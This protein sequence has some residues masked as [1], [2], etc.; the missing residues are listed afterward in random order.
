VFTACPVHVCLGN[1]VWCVP[2]APCSEEFDESVVPALP[3]A[4]QPQTRGSAYKVLATLCNG[5]PENLM[6]L[7]QRLSTLVAQTTKVQRAYVG[8]WCGGCGVRAV[9][10]GRWCGGCGVG[11]VVWGLW[12]G[13][14]GMGAVVWGRWCGGCGVVLRCMGACPV[15]C[16]STP[17]AKCSNTLLVLNDGNLGNEIH[18]CRFQVTGFKFN[19]LRDRK[20][21]TGYV[22]IKN[23][24]YVSPSAVRTLPGLRCCATLPSSHGCICCLPPF[25]DSFSV[26]QLYSL[27]LFHCHLTAGLYPMSC[28]PANSGASAT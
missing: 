9:V 6:L 2:V 22:G 19:I 20:S 24:G 3:K 15:L 4:K 17:C 13:G 28:C 27:L 14:Y 8:L 25:N 16:R 10:W 12:C 21:A 23:L 11:A 18:S 7:M 26:S 5:C 1:A